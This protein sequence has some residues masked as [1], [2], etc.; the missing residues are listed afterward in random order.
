MKNMVVGFVLGLVVATVGFS[1]VARLLDR[2]VDTIKQ[3]S[4]ELSK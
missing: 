3:Q 2:G 1:G 4:Q